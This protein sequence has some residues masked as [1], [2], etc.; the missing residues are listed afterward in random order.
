MGYAS[1]FM[2]EV[3]GQKIIFK[4]IDCCGSGGHECIA[5]GKSQSQWGNEIEEELDDLEES[6]S[7]RRE[8]ANISNI[9]TRTRSFNNC[10]RYS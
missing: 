10:K 7:I 2:T 1:G 3:C 8:R 5:V 6:I 4:E 9:I